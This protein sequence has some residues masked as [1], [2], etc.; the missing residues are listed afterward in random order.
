MAEQSDW[1]PGIPIP[2]VAAILD[3]EDP[4]RYQETDD[5]RDGEAAERGGHSEAGHGGQD[6]R[7]RLEDR[8]LDD[9]PGCGP[10]SL[11]RQEPGVRDEERQS[12]DWI[13]GEGQGRGQA[14]AGVRGRPGQAPPDRH[15]AHHA[16]A[17]GQQQACLGDGGLLPAAIL[18]REEE[19]QSRGNAERR[20]GTHHLEGEQHLAIA[21]VLL[22][23]PAPRQNAGRHDR[24]EAADDA[25][26]H[27]QEGGLLPRGLGAVHGDAGGR[28]RSLGRP[29]KGP[30]G[31]AVTQA[32]TAAG[33]SGASGLHPGLC[34]FPIDRTALSRSGRPGYDPRPF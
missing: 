15:R 18:L 29:R 14:A 19:G 1:K 11:D 23:A 30:A 4:H 20:E 21:A 24:K 22:F 13:E 8:G 6:R 2:L 12:E 34:P 26:G 3:A 7:R 32:L 16:A 33:G 17:A 28:C 9:E 31:T 10:A 27:E 5:R 25:A